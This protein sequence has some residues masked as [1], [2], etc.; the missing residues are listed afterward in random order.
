MD[1]LFDIINDNNNNNQHDLSVT[2]YKCSCPAC[3]NGLLD[4][5]DNPINTTTSSNTPSSTTTS[6][7]PPIDAVLSGYKWTV[8]TNRVITFSFYENDVFNGSYYGYETGV[9][10]VSNAV[11]N[12]VRSIMSWLENVINIDFQEVTETNTSTYGQIRFMD[13]DSP[14]YAYAYFPGG[15][16]LGVS[17]D[18]HLRSSYDRLG[19]TNGFQNLAG[20]HGYMSLIHELGHA[21]GLKHTHDGGLDAALDNTDNSVMT[22]NFTGNSAGTYMPLDIKALQSLYGAK[23]FNTG[24]D[25]YVFTTS[26]D[27]FTVNGVSLLNTTNLTKQALWDSGGTD[28]LD[29]SALTYKS[30]GYQM[31][32]NPGGL[33]SETFGATTS[34]TTAIAYDVTI[35]NVINSS[36]NDKI[37]LNSGANTISGYL[38]NKV[39]RNDVIYN[40]NSQDTLKLDYTNAAVTKTQSGQDLIL[41]LGSNGSIKLV[42]YYSD[43]NNQIKINYSD[44]NIAPPPPPPVS[45]NNELSLTINGTTKTGSLQSY[46]AASINNGTPSPQDTNQAVVTYST[47]K[48]EVQIDNNGWKQFG[49]GNY[50]ITANTVLTFDFLS[51]KEGEIQGIGFDNNDN[52]FD[53]TNALFQLHG[54]QTWG[55]QAFNNYTAANGWKTYSINV[56][57]YFTGNYDRLGFM[58]DDDRTT[59]NISSQFRNIK[60]SEANLTNTTNLNITV[61]GTTKTGSLESYGAA[62]IN[63]GTPSPQDTTQAV[64]TYFSNINEVQIENNGWKQFGIGNY[65]ITANTVLTFDFLST[66]EGEIQGIGFDNNDNIFDDTNALFQLHGTQ[67]WGNQAFNNYTAANG[68]KTYSINVG[69]YFTGNYD[70]LGFMNDDDRTTPN[71]SSQFRN[72]KIEESATLGNTLL[73][74]ND[75]NTKSG[76]K[77][78]LEEISSNTG[79]D[80]TGIKKDQQLVG[81]KALVKL[82]IGTKGADTFILGDELQTYHDQAGYKDFAL[83]KGFNT[84]Q[85]DVIQLHGDQSLYDVVSFGKGNYE[86]SAIFSKAG[87]TDELIGVV[88]GVNSL[89]LNS[90][91]F[92][93]V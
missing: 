23:Q 28:T 91:A 40:G 21:L 93:F 39:T 53:D 73:G 46:G 65:N 25:T 10:E 76:S 30:G 71:I 14:S 27:K 51:T 90:S 86:A 45:N 78:I 68:W 12:N 74:E 81:Q 69:D 49:I 18:V 79:I 70:R 43:L 19:D 38:T 62:S 4:N 34:Y 11:K 48:S 52:I 83:I 15:S 42:N 50:N 89:D 84:Q 54:T 3:L 31:D 13:S 9:K 61:N 2:D 59:P 33:L 29:F 32:L 67:T 80:L 1:N 92:S 22:Y 66:K 88:S 6:N 44:S 60:I 41:G 20:K 55:N 16:G 77:T 85:G 72:I 58:N 47:D 8:P 57:D 7:N 36:S 35:E 37:Y 26:I 5:N 82:E 75:K 17:G 63:N 56:G 24:N 87:N 64:V